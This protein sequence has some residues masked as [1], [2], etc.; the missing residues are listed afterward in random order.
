M[1]SPISIQLNPLVGEKQETWVILY[2][3]SSS[4]EPSDEQN[5]R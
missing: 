1:I 3:S 2:T 5:T 4:V